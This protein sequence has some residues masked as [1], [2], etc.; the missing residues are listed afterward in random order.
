MSVAV[1]NLRLFPT[2]SMTQCRRL[3]GPLAGVSIVQRTDHMREF[4]GFGRRSEPNCFLPLRFMLINCACRMPCY[5]VMAAPA[6]SN[7]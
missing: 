4:E 3:Q 7:F 5:G 6:E 2:N 1:Q